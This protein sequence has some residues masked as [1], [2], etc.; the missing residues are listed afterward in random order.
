MAEWQEDEAL[1]VADRQEVLG[2]RERERRGAALDIRRPGEAANRG[3]ITERPYLDRALTVNE[4]HELPVGRERAGLLV[5]SRRE[6]TLEPSVGT[7]PDAE[8]TVA[9]REEDAQIGPRPSR[10]PVS[11]RAEVEPNRLG[12]PGRIDPL[13]LDTLRDLVG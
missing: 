12:S 10:L 5:H 6:G 8:H 9:L 13:P 2:R 3:A 7:P 1:R 11:L 4:R